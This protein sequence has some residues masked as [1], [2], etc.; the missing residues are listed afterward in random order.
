M[1]RKL[2]PALRKR[3]K[4]EVKSPGRG[5]RK[6]FYGAFAASA[7]VGS[8]IFGLRL[9]SGTADSNTLS[10]LAL[11]LGILGLMVG[12]LKIENRADQP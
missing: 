2:D 11:Q 7:L 10:N 8:F 6:V 12:L 9:L 4:A 5:F 3:L 1:N